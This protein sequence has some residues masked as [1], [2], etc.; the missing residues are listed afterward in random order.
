[1]YRE[2]FKRMSARHGTGALEHG[3][4]KR[5][6]SMGMLCGD[7]SF[8]RHQGREMNPGCV[9]TRVHPFPKVDFQSLPFIQ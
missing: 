1:M 7:P 5:N 6:D 9:N 8:K 4:K 3:L 2:P